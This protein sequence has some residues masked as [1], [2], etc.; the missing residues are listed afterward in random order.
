VLSG[1]TFF[2][3]PRGAGEET[4]IIM[5]IVSSLLSINLSCTVDIP[6]AIFHGL[7]TARTSAIDFPFPLPR[8]HSVYTANT[9]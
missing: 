7:H 3:C 6:H 1:K 9:N 2:P 4:I 5:F 8:H